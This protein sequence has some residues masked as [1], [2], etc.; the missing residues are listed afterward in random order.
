V[1]SGG[2]DDLSAESLSAI[3]WECEYV[4]ERAIFKV[5]AGVADLEAHDGSVA[6]QRVR[7]DD[8]K[9]NRVMLGRVGL[10]HEGLALE[11]GRPLHLH[12][13]E[14]LPFENERKIR[15]SESD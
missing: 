1:R 12:E 10:A 9:M 7:L 6:D 15:L 3:R 14:R 2:I 4:P 8:G 5:L 13:G 11:H